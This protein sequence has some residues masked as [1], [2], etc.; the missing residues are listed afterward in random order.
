VKISPIRD[1][2]RDAPTR[3]APGSKLLDIEMDI[4]MRS[5]LH[6]AAPNTY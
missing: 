6:H 3:R 2:Q 5:T 4:I 1:V